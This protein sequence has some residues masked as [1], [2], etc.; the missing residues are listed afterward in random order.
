MIIQERFVSDEKC[1][2]AAIMVLFH[3]CKHA[4]AFPRDVET[5]T[6]FLQT[7]AAKESVAR[8]KL[9]AFVT[10]LIDRA[11]RAEKELKRLRGLDGSTSGNLTAGPSLVRSLPRLVFLHC[12]YFLSTIFF[13]F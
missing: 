4:F 3:H 12:I 5:L 6:E 13:K 8:C 7:A 1:V 2:T 9:E 10:E 11:D